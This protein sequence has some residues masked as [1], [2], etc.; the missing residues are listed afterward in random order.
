MQDFL[1]LAQLLKFALGWDLEDSETFVFSGDN[2]YM[3]PAR[4]D[5]HVNNVR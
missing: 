2:Y 1:P 3:I 5:H 4:S